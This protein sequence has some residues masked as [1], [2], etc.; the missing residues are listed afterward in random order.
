M[1]SFTVEKHFTSLQKKKNKKKS[2]HSPAKPSQQKGD[3][4]D[5]PVDQL[6]VAQVKT[7]VATEMVR[8]MI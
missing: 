7:S 3:L 4:R 2:R 5:C 1:I 8:K 6:T